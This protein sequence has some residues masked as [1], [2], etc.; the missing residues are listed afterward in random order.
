MWDSS[1]FKCNK[2]RTR[3]V[4][5]WSQWKNGGCENVWNYF[6]GRMSVYIMNPVGILGNMM[7]LEGRVLQKQYAVDA[8]NCDEH[9]C[10]ESRMHYM[11]AEQDG[12]YIWCDNACDGNQIHNFFNRRF[13]SHNKHLSIVDSIGGVC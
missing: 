2:K 7:Y 3:P 1:F 12:R 10:Q 8:D 6:P 4:S 11:N 9:T 5:H 13:C